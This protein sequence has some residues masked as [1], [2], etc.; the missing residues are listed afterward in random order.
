MKTFGKC[1]QVYGGLYQLSD[2]S[3]VQCLSKQ[4]L[5]F[6]TLYLNNSACWVSVTW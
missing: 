1:S 6:K 2:I 4:I 3:V 5:T